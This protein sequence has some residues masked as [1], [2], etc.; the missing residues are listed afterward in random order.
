MRKLLLMVS[1]LLIFSGCSNPEPHEQLAYETSDEELNIFLV[2]DANTELVE[3]EVAVD[4]DDLVSQ[5][6]KVMDLLL[7]GDEASGLKA[8]VSEQDFIEAIEVGNG[9]VE[10]HVSEGFVSQPEV[11][12]LICRSS[13]IKSMTAIDGVDNVTFYLDG[14]PMKDR[15]GKVYGS[16]QTDDVITRSRDGGGLNRSEALTLYYPDTKSNVLIAV[17]RVVTL[18]DTDSLEGKVLEELIS[19]QVPDGLQRAIPSGTVLRKV[20]VNNGICYIDFSRAYSNISYDT[21]VSPLLSTYSVVNSLTELTH[22]NRV[23]FMVEGEKVASSIGQTPSPALFEYNI[24]IIG[25]R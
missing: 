21:D 19:G 16:F 25:N 18:D 14:M 5:V 6:Q 24:E 8:T 15:K 10:I 20:T 13:I 12:Q 3:I 22:I 1:L 23:Q 9:T 4:D 17:K 11:E 2:N 7:Y